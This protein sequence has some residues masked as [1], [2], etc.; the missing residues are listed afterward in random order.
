VAAAELIFRH[1]TV[2]TV[3][4]GFSLAEAVAVS[5]GSIVAVGRDEDVEDL[6]GPNTHVVD[7]DG[8]AV[9]PGINDSHIHAAMLG[10]YWP[11]YW[12]DGMAAGDGFPVPRELHTEDDRRAALR[13]AWDVLL[14]LGV[15]SYTEPGLGPGADHQH[16]AACGTAVLDTYRQLAAEAQ[17]PIRVS[18]LALFGELDGPCDPDVYAAAVAELN[19]EHARR[20]RRLRLAGVKIFAD[21]IPPAGSAWMHEPYADGST[22]ALL[23]PGNDD[24]ERVAVLD[25]MVDQ[26]HARGLQVGVHAT[27]S[28]TLDATVDAFIRAGQRNDAR[29]LRHYVIHADASSSR[30]LELMARHGVGLNTQAAIYTA[31]APLLDGMIGRERTERA[32]PLRTALDAGVAV[33]LSSDSPVMAPDWR[34]GIV[35]AVRRCDP[36]GHVRGAGEGIGVAEAIRAYTIVP[37]RQDCAESWKGSIEVGKVADLCVLDASPLAVPVDQIPQ[38]GIRMTVVDG[39]VVYRADRSGEAGQAIGSL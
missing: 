5:A 31:T 14:P 10:A 13:R 30:A 6:I 22:G 15:T 12:M 35:A 36:S 19:A 37:A 20:D 34:T 25:A 3:D 2:I 23:M 32:F 17:L 16:G 1:G 33:S 7:L 28:A 18:V 29:D 39:E 9:L 24:S 26:A 11:D 8:G 4:A 27:G 21:G 38:I